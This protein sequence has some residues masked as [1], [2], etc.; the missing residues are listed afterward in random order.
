MSVIDYTLKAIEDFTKAYKK[1]K[2]YIV[3]NNSLKIIKINYLHYAYDLE[4]MYALGLQHNTNG[5]NFCVLGNDNRYY[6]CNVKKMRTKEEALK[7]VE[8][9]KAKR[10]Q[11]E[12]DKKLKMFKQLK[13]ELGK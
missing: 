10:Q 4:Y 2:K 12:L 7:L 5:D 3:D 9:E 13:K 6:W 8:K 1:G 11:Q